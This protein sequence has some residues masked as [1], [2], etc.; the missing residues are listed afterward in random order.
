MGATRD[1]SQGFAFVFPGKTI[2]LNKD[3]SRTRE[4]IRRE[5]D[6]LILDSLVKEQEE[7]IKPLKV[8]GANSIFTIH[9]SSS[10]SREATQQIRENLTRL[11]KLHNKLHEMLNDLKEVSP[12]TPSKKRGR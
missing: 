6:Q 9:S 8:K 11:Q 12:K 1:R 10:T 5:Q 2:N 4:D 3:N 7:A